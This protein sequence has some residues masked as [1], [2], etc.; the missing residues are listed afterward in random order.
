MTWMSRLENKVK[1]F[2][3]L[4]LINDT[5]VGLYQVLQCDSQTLVYPHR[6]C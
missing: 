5:G 2:L 4:L 3:A 6:Y 1:Q